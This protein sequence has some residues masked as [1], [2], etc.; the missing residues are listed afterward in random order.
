MGR[1]ALVL[2]STLVAAAPSALPRSVP[3]VRLAPKPLAHCGKAPLLRPICPTL[4]PHVRA[5]FL[6]HLS[7]KPLLFDL[8]RG[9][10]DPNA[11]ERNRPPRMAH[12]VLAAGNID[13]IAPYT[14]PVGKRFALENG[15]MRR[16][17]KLPI[18]FGRVRWA[19]KSGVLFL[20]PPFVFGGEIG[21]HLVFRWRE[22]RT[23]YLV[24]L[25]AWEPLRETAATL[26]AIV[27]ST[28]AASG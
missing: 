3:L 8:Q 27:E 22:R 9:G 5:S 10:E 24:S 17:R 15:L 20:A 19:G 2:V 23:D 13:G 12:I 16:P 26:R 21:N 4:V 11:P 25:H 14:R 28:P 1:L 7:R 6:S 18:S